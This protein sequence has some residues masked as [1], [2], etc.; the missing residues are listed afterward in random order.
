MDL[1]LIQ[2][3]ALSVAALHSS[4]AEHSMVI[5]DVKQKGLRTCHNSEYNKLMIVYELEEMLN[6]ETSPFHFVPLL[7]HFFQVFFRH[8]E[9]EC[10]T[11]AVSQ[12]IDNIVEVVPERHNQHQTM[13]GQDV[14]YAILHI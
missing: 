13:R 11:N 5:D 8:F 12:D 3:V 10:H 1:D 14:Q 9:N 6:T 7:L 4:Q 2:G